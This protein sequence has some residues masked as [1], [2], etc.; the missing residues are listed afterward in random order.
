MPLHRKKVL[1]KCVF[2]TT[3]IVDHGTLNVEPYFPIPRRMTCFI[4]KNYPVP[5]P[6]NKYVIYDTNKT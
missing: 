4:I 5:D 1:T 6:G 3:I 2:L